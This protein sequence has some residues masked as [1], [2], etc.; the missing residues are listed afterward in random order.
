MDPDETLKVYERAVR[1]SDTESA[2]IALDDLRE[3]R[4]KGGFAPRKG[5]PRGA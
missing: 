5:W 4:R 2:R 1:E 3:W